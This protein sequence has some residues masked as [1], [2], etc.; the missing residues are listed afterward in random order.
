MADIEDISSVDTQTKQ[1][2]KLSHN[3]NH[4]SRIFTNAEYDIISGELMR[5][6]E[7]GPLRGRMLK[8]G[9]LRT[10]RIL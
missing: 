1:L 8:G 3:N 9:P 6:I 7:G 10:A 4:K 2:S 5:A